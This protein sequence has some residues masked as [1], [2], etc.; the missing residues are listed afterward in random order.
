M[1]WARVLAFADPLPCAAALQSKV[2]AE[3]LPTERGRFGA[4]VTQ[5]GI[6]KLRMQR[7]AMALPQVI[8]A[9]TSPDRKAIGF[10]TEANASTLRHCGFEVLPSNIVVY[11]DDVLHQRSSY[12]FRYATMSLPAKDFPALCK[13]IIGREFLAERRT[14]LVRPDP[15][16]MTRLLKIH[17]VVGQ[18]AQDT[19]D[20]LQQEEVGRALEEQ[21]IHI[22]IRCLAE[23]AGVETTTGHGRHHAIIERFEDF[24]AAH[25]DRPLYLTEICAGV[26]AAERTLR[27]ACEEHLGMG[28]IRFLTL[29]RMHLVRQAL[30]HADHSKVTVT[31]IV[32]NHG[33]WEL[34]RF[35]V[36]YRTLFGET[37]SE[38]LRRPAEHAVVDL[39]RP[40]SLSAMGFPAA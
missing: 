28:P 25:P 13:T 17:K 1:A 12:D 8:T 38:T 2:Q 31:R 16:L 32:T 29:R 10:L 5:I 23:A 22:M 9:V 34:G 36:A 6:G 19:P 7:F 21:L 18:L 33:F 15:T 40:L 24:L 4:E 20:I 39:D 3:I 26:G 27:A 14:S 37:P 30:L 11:G 35:S